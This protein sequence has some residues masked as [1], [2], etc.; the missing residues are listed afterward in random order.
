M[1]GP[2]N[3]NKHSG[4]VSPVTSSLYVLEE[5]KAAKKPRSQANKVCPATDLQKY[6]CYRYLLRPDSTRTQASLYWIHENA[7][8][9]PSNGDADKHPAVADCPEE[10]AVNQC[11]GRL[12]LHSVHVCLLMTTQSMGFHYILRQRKKNTTNQDVRDEWT[13]N[14]QLLCLPQFLKYLGL[15]CPL[16]VAVATTAAYTQ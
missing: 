11:C 2:R 10:M 15:P 13:S 3:R 4:H 8:K 7:Q 16:A 9:P 14:W 5:V 1:K 6:S 12:C